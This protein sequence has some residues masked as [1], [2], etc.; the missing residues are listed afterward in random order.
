VNCSSLAINQC[1]LE[2]PH[3]FMS[4]N[5]SD[6]F[7][8]WTYADTSFQLEFKAFLGRVIRYV[9][10]I[11]ITI[12]KDTRRIGCAGR[13]WHALPVRSR[14]C[15]CGPL[16]SAVKDEAPSRVTVDNIIML[17]MGL[18]SS[19]FPRFL[20]SKWHCKHETCSPGVEKPREET[21]RGC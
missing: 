6:V 10:E 21:V 3:R 11:T 1:Q 2:T 16:R 15:A 17:N 5:N 18:S 8:R 20:H 12:D 19:A 4:D 9:L 13:F 14:S 7:V